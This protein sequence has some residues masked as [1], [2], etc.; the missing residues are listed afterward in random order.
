MAPFSIILV[1]EFCVTIYICNNTSLKI[2]Q[3]YNFQLLTYTIARFREALQH[4]EDGIEQSRN[5]C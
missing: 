4:L 2:Q 5:K 3:L 1:G